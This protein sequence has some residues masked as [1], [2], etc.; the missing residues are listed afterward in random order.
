MRVLSRWRVG[1][2]VR[3]VR[4]EEVNVR[5]DDKT[6]LNDI[7]LLSQV[8]RGQNNSNDHPQLVRLS[9]DESVRIVANG[10]T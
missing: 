5:Q 9:D 7:V 1:E 3:V 4:D 6:L 8:T 2:S 10:D